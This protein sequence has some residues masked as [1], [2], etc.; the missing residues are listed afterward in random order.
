MPGSF[1]SVDWTTNEPICRTSVDRRGNKGGQLFPRQ[2]KEQGTTRDSNPLLHPKECCKSGKATDQT[3]P[4][5]P[6]Y[7]AT[8]ASKIR[9]CR[10]APATKSL[11][12]PITSLHNRRQSS[13]LP[14]TL[15]REGRTRNEIQLQFPKNARDS[16]R[17]ARPLCGPRTVHPRLLRLLVSQNFFLPFEPRKVLKT[18]NRLKARTRETAEIGGLNP[19]VNPVKW[20]NRTTEQSPHHGRGW[21]DLWLSAPRRPAAITM[22]NGDCHIAAQNLVFSLWCRAH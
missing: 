20:R 19:A 17:R 1:A 16:S 8:V 9:A 7:A 15:E 22:R 10:S 5:I 13:C 2:P 21:D 14:C 12:F 18:R 11:V 6:S 3:V 4:T